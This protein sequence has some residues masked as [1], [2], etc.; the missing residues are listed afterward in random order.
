MGN[1]AKHKRTYEHLWVDED[2]V[3]EEDKE[4]M[5]QRQVELRGQHEENVSPCVS[6]PLVHL[7]RDFL[8]YP[9]RTISIIIL[10]FDLYS[11][12]YI[13]HTIFLYFNT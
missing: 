8:G 6:Q 2:E 7:T 10:A 12:K 1:M 11:G 3:Q 9:L 4:R 5:Q 13:F